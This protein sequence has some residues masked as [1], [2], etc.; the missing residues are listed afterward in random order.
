MIIVIIFRTLR[1]V[2]QV[3]RSYFVKLYNRPLTLIIAAHSR[4]HIAKNSTALFR[5]LWNFNSI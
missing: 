4:S 5:N 3:R 1:F 2:E